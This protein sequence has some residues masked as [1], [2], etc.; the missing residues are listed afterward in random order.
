MKD[1]WDIAMTIATGAAA[2]IALGIA[3]RQERIRS[4]SEKVKANVI[5]AGLAP[6]LEV[7]VEEL[8]NFSTGLMFYD[9]TIGHHDIPL[10]EAK[11]ILEMGRLY[12]ENEDIA[13]LSILGGNCAYRL[14]LAIS[15]LDI[16]I[17]KIQADV[18]RSK[19]SNAPLTETLAVEWAGRID[20]AIS[21][22]EI[23]ERE[24]KQAASIPAAF[25]TAQERYGDP[26]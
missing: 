17:A 20:E 24:C 5:A 4:G 9:V 25:P 18:D 10:H 7:L 13:A 1:G 11:T 6:R 26:E 19:N 16:A 2:I 23:V 21:L 3:I 8:R 14:A 12:I 22:L 15:L